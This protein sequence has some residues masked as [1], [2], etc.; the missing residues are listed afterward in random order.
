MQNMK[1]VVWIIGVLLALAAIVG[2]VVLHRQTTLELPDYPAAARTVWLQQDWSADERNWFHHADQGTQTFRIPYEWFMALEQPAWSLSPDLLSDSA[3]L[4]R[5]GFIPEPGPA[6][7]RDLPI[8]F[9]HGGEMRAEDGSAWP[10]PQTS[11][12]M[13]RVG[14]T[15]AACHTGRFTFQNTAV[16]IDGG[17]AITNVPEFQKAVGLAL[18][19]TQWVPFRFGRFADRVLGSNARDDAKAALLQQLKQVVAKYGEIKNLEDA[20]KSQGVEEGY[21]RLDALNRIGN[22]VFSLDANKPENYVGASAPVHY[23]RIWNSP[24]FRWV[25]YNGSIGQPMIRNA[26]EALGVLAWLDMSSEGSKRFSST[27]QI[28]TIADLEKLLAGNQPD[29][30]HGFSGLNAPKWPSEVLPP[31]KPQL[32]ATGAGLYK[33]LCQECH[34]APVTSPEFWASERWLPP[35]SAGQRY[36]DLELIDIKHIGTDPSQAEDMKNRRLTISPTL[37]LDSTEFG[38]ALGQIVELAAQRWYDDQQPPTPADVRDEMNGHRAN[39]IQAVLKY[40]VR[41]LNGVWAAPPYLHNG[42]VPNV[43]ALLSPVDERP[44]TF[45]LGNREYDPVHLGYRTEVVPGGFELDTSLKGNNNT[46]HEFNNVQG[47]EGV[48]GR[49]LTPDER[50]ALIEYLKTL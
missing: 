49:L 33:E 22:A 20:V 37:G 5:F 19:Y 3:Y 30:E 41:P 17:P 24:W 4:D 14:F 38:P 10:N 28:Q 29:I 39:G 42:S 27:V 43:Y 36:L 6:G 2:G 45:G 12:T 26:G 48:I 9:A 40:K 7:A 13:S 11:K 21:A 34:L 44:R 25:Q 47:K 8:G 32:A 31:I 35:N 1:R 15:C 18:L 50:L 46:G 16:L 23:P